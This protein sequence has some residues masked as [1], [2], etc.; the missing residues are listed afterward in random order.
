M[1]G[2]VIL[3]VLLYID[4]SS[5]RLSGELIWDDARGIYC[6]GYHGTTC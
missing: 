2:T 6:R 3:G 4:S 5:Q 1:L